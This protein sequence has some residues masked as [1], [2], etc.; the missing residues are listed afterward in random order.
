M[1]TI[2]Y[3]IG[4]LVLCV[5]SMT[6]CKKNFLTVPATDRIDNSSI[7]SDTSLFEAYVINRYIGVKLQDK[8]DDDTGF[9]RGFQWAFWSSLTD[10][11][12]YNNN[13]NTWVIQ[14]G[15]L[16]P[17]NL[18]DAGTIWARS[19]RSIRECNYALS[20]I[21]G[22]PLSAGHKNKLIGELK[23]IRAFRYQDLIRNYGGVVLMGDKVTELTDNLQDPSL[24]NRATI[25]QSIT[26][27]SSEL[28][29]AA[30]RLPVD[31]GTSWALGRATKGAALALKSRL[32]LYAASPLYN[33]GTWQAAAAA[34]KAVMDL[35]KYSL[36][37]GGYGQLF[38]TPDNNEIIFERLFYPV[39]AAHLPIELDNGPNSYGGYGGN[40]PLQNMV[41]AYQMNNGKSITDPAS[42]YDS[43]N[44][45]VNRDPR[46]Y[47]TILYNGAPYRNNIV[48]VFLPGGKD[49]NQGPNPQNASKTGYYLK[50][51]ANDAYSITSS[52]EAGAQPWIY[53]RYA[54]I[55]LNYAEAQNEAVGP[56]ASVY[57]AIN[58]IRQ[59]TSVNMPTLSGLS[60]NDMRTAIRNERQ[61]ELAFE[62]HRFYDVRRWQIA[63][64]TEN[65]PA[66]GIAVGIN[67][68]S[69]SGYSYTSKIAL[70]GRA[71][72]SQHYWLP[73]PLAEIQA[74]NGQ[75]KQNPG[76]TN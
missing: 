15:Q 2:Q 53:F 73:I 58:A 50:K 4:C 11:S 10:E 14:Q 17:N 24:F 69:P 72:L 18:G 46:F 48:Q 63:S 20:I 62:E 65:V 32:L 22:L 5:V 13:D 45:Y 6:S 26:Y 35:G 34:A 25:A 66:Y 49:S 55:L 23:F 43:Q 39:T 38:L 30:S 8:E 33:A 12:I 75:L 28:D 27:A 29:D 61:I 70:T 41:D 71:F 68:A 40:V 7:L 59:R 16:A 21:N 52:N 31:N 57:Q 44:P 54:E 64:Q 67:S 37:Q 36:F 51:F 74:S 1:K 76:Y 3:I 47:A 42:G 19:Y 9:G 60:Q 56:D